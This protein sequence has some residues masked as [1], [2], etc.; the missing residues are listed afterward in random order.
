[1]AQPMMPPVA[2]DPVNPALAE[3]AKLDRW[4]CWRLEQRDP[5]KPPTKVPYRVGGKRKAASTIP[6]TWSSFDLCRRSAFRQHNADGIGFVVDGSDDL[7]GF[8]LDDCIVNG[9]LAPW[10]HAIAERL[11]SYTERSPSGTGLR[12]FV[13]G[14]IPDDGRKRPYHSGKI[15]VYARARFFTITGDHVPGFPNRI[16]RRPK[17]V[18]T[19]FA[20]LWPTP[21]ASAVNGEGDWPPLPVPASEALL[22]DYQTKF[23][24]LFAGRYPSASEGDFALACLAYKRGRPREEAAALVRKVRQIAEDPKGERADYVWRTVARAY[25]DGEAAQHDL[26]RLIDEACTDPAAPFEP[27]AIDF[28][29]E[30]RER[31]PANYERA[32]ARLRKAHVRVAELDKHVERRCPEPEGAGGRLE[33]AEIE[34]WPE[35]V[36]GAELLNAMTVH[37]EHFAIMPEYGASATA[38]FALHCHTLDAAIHTPRLL[39]TSPVHECGKGQVIVWLD[40]IVPRPFN[41]LDPTGPTLFR[42]I[43][44]HCPTVLIDEADLISWQDRR[45]ILAVIHAGHT[46]HGQGIP[47][48]VGDSN[49]TR[50]FRVWAPLAYAMIGKPRGPLLSRSI[51]IRME[52]K[53]PRQTVEHRRIDRDQGFG[54][55]RRKCARWA[56]DHLDALR[57]AEP[58]LPVVGRHADCWRALVAIADAAGGDWPERAREAARALSGIAVEDQTIGVQLLAAIK[59]VFGGRRRIST[60]KLL[61]LLHGLPEQP[62]SEYGRTRRPIT[63]NQLAD[64]LRPFKIRSKQVKVLGVNKRGFKREHFEEV[65]AR[66]L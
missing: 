41:V 34:P 7:V 8:D 18:A 6:A 24:D 10:A 42:P 57:D 44:A 5:D 56:T 61:Q 15:E 49:E 64:L 48:C 66:Y 59:Q 1:M 45:D 2:D 29:A 51:I 16:L 4:V 9:E 22:D 52:R 39:I 27:T 32:R 63:D 35:P 53:A 40:G 19:L 31:N 26:E 20:E 38:L 21:R 25:A 46:K 60:E 55:L 58:E 30:L 33:F 28:L 47:R 65:W 14:T 13:R 11:G 62:W 50:V 36:D 54:E 23:P 37:L 3:L 17:A 12:I 43:E